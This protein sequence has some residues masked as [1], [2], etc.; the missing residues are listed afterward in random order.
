VR[1]TR[2][3][4]F[5]AG[6][7]SRGPRSCAT[8]SARKAVARFRRRASV[9]GTPEGMSTFRKLARRITVADLQG[10]LGPPLRLAMSSLEAWEE[11]MQSADGYDPI[12]R[13]SLVYDDSGIPTHYCWFQALNAV[14]ELRPNAEPL[15]T[16]LLLTSDT[17]ALDAVL[18][19]GLCE[20]PYAFV[21]RQ[22][23]ITGVISSADFYKP[24]FAICVL[25]LL[26]EVEDTCIREAMGDPDAAWNRLR[27]QR[28]GL[29]LKVYA[30]RYDRDPQQAKRSTLLHCTMFSDKLPMVRQAERSVA[31]ATR[32]CKTTSIRRSVSETTSR[33]MARTNGWEACALLRNS[34]QIRRS[35][36]R[37][38]RRR[39]P[40]CVWF[41]TPTPTLEPPA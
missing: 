21:M 31:L 6:G 5:E 37:H 22:H 8:F 34:S 40:D 1:E 25:A 39:G 15:H 24:E 28:Q 3:K 2:A 12:D 26:L 14:G 10:P 11:L 27:S 23:E 17:T 41:M 4:R 18:R 9:G 30:R 19:L 16:G 20:P 33:I 29:A 13:V 38:S 7:S 32:G 35:C 36:L